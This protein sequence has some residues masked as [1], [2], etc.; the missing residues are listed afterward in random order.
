VIF[1]FLTELGNIVHKDAKMNKIWK[2]VERIM[3]SQRRIE[4]D[5]KIKKVQLNYLESKL[6]RKVNKVNRINEVDE[7]VYKKSK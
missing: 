6:N 5:M 2:G 3:D 7:R 1:V 4:D